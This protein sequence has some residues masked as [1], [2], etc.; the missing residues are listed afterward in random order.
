[1]T[2]PAQ[3]PQGEPVYAVR[4]APDSAVASYSPAP[5]TNA[6]AVIALVAS[7][8]GWTF[9]PVVGS[10]LGIVMGYQ[11]RKAIAS[12]GE[13]GASMATV[14]IVLGWIMVGLFVLS[15]VIALVFMIIAVVASS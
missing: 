12:S 13:S 3:P 7:V 5:P 6:M 14:A 4:P 15:L 10:V 9:F 1:M 8:L 2:T 11:A